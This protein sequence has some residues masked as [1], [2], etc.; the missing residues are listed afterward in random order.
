MSSQT[1]LFHKYDFSAV[2]RNL[3]EQV[4]KAA[5][6][7]P[8]HELLDGTAE[9]I[10][11]RLAEAHA[12]EVPA[13]DLENVAPTEQ[14]VDLDVSGDPRR[15]TF[16]HGGPCYVKATEISFRVPFTGDSKM[17]LCCP[18]TSTMNPP[19]ADIEGN[20]VIVRI[21]RTD[22]DATAFRTAF[23]ETIQSIEKY[24]DWL[25]SDVAQLPTA[26]R[27]AALARVQQRREKR[28]KD[29]SLIED[30]GFGKPGSQ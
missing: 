9:E 28:K 16:D 19:H 5:D 18:S 20:S 14:E 7:L 1:L 6:E 3:P 12:I 29:K 8:D 11:E 2:C 25:R 4:K 13:L 22:Q 30:L 23:D 15:M 10:A 27:Q 17:F 21:V 24:L 26:I